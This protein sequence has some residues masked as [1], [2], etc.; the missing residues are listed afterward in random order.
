MN[1]APEIQLFVFIVICF[2]YGFDRFFTPPLWRFFKLLKVKK[3][4]LMA[5]V[6]FFERVINNSHPHLIQ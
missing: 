2:E 6:N 3:K 4:F 1:I 5:I